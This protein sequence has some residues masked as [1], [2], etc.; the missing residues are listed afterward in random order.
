LTDLLASRQRH[1]QSPENELLRA[2]QK[3]VQ[4]LK[5]D[6]FLSCDFC[7]WANAQ[8]ETPW[9]DKPLSPAKLADMLRIY[10]LHPRQINRI[11]NGKQ[12]NCRGYVVADFDSVF[13]CYLEK[14]SVA[15]GTE[16]N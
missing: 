10:D 5:A 11:V 15:S 9:S 8:E 14:P 6:R 16:S 7:A 3:Y 13:N 12:K 4:E 2:V 1:Q